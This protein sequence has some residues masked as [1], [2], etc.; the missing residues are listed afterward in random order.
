M[1]TTSK[2]PRG[3]EWRKWD[4]H[5]HSPGTKKNDGY[6][7][8][9][10]DI[11]DEY[12][13]R[14]ED[15]DV[16]VFGLTDYFS[17]DGY[18]NTIKEFGRRYAG[19]TKTFFANI[20]L[21][22][23]DVV[24]KQRDEVNLH[25][26]FNPSVSTKKLKE[27]LSNLQT[28]KTDSKGRNVTAAELKSEADFECATTTREFIRDALERTFGSKAELTDHL[29]IFTAIN[30]DGIRAERGAKRKAAISDELD[31]FSNGFFGNSNNTPY[32]LDPK[33]LDCFVSGFDRGTRFPA[34][35]AFRSIEVSYFSPCG[36]RPIYFA[37]EPDGQPDHFG[38]G[39][40]G[41]DPR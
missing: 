35:E 10:T 17:A 24:N 20:E 29:L 1:S 26:V 11:W 31:K 28:N 21:C 39:H 13:E 22:T 40:C 27:F 9:A 41:G 8:S 7:G 32:Y 3:S 25:V 33:R 30:N 34:D 14:I 19:S 23:S 4:L 38:P 15:S 6:K 2:H 5:L 18:L 12:C 37:T 16:Q 36:H